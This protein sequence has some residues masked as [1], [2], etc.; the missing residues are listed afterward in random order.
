M[1]S[2]TDMKLPT[3]IRSI[4]REINTVILIS[5]FCVL[6]VMGADLNISVKQLSEIEAFLAKYVGIA[7]PFFLGVAGFIFWVVGAYVVEVFLSTQ[8]RGW[9]FIIKI[10][11]WAAEACPYVGL[12]TT[13]YTFLNALLVYSKAGPGTPETQAAFIGQFA[14]AFGSS[15]TGGILALFAF[16]LRALILNGER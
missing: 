1:N 11:D 14:I 9:T 8:K 3:R 4:N 10:L 6:I 7:W 12:L 15:I 2:L 16:T 13:F 5:I